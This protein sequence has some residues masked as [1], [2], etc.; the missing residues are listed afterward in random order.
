MN[1]I[2]AAMA[3]K[4]IPS[5]TPI[6]A[7][8]TLSE[9][10]TV[11]NEEFLRAHAHLDLHSVVAGVLQQL[12]YKGRFSGSGSKNVALVGDP[13]F[14]W[15]EGGQRMHPKLVVRITSLAYV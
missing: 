4:N 9:P 10:T 5:G 6:N 15:I 3:N 1:A 12:G 2:L 7:G 13:D 8:N 14:A 11:S